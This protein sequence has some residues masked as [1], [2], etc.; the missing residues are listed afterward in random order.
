M[1]SKY[2][3]ALEKARK[4]EEE[5]VQRLYKA[6][7]TRQIAQYS[8]EGEFSKAEA[9]SLIEDALEFVNRI[10]ELLR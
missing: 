10:G 7:R 5:Y 9:K 4:L 6:K 3:T 1:E 2:V 8:V